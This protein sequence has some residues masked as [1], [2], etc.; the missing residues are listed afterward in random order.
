MP[1]VSACEGGV[2]LGVRAQPKAS[3]NAIVGRLGDRLKIAVTAAPTSGKANEALAAVVAEA[4]GV[5]RS[6]VAVVAG[7]ASRDKVVRVAGLGTD[8]A[9]RRIDTLLASRAR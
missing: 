7:H 2:H 4:L 3:R 6:A 1:L 5:R 9:R 8:E